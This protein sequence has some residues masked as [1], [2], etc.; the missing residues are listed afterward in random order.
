M[1]RRRRGVAED[2]RRQDALRVLDRGLE[3]QLAEDLRAALVTPGGRRLLWW[4]I[5]GVS[6]AMGRS[7]AQDPYATAYN[8][9]RRSVGVDVRLA[10]ERADS[11]AYVRM[12]RE[13]LDAAERRALTARSEP[14]EGDD[15]E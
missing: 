12:I 11:A 13:Q 8:E 15:D 6:G 7:F 1:S 3:A 10:C 9:G 14:R 2:E 5:D 4:V